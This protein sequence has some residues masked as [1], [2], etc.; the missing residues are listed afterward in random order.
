[1][2]MTATTV[3]QRIGIGLIAEAEQI[4]GLSDWGGDEFYEPFRLLV[5]SLVADAQLSPAGVESSREWLLMRLTQR[6]KL[7]ED[8]KRHPAI[9]EQRIEHPIFVAGMPRAGTTFMHGLLASDPVAISP[10]LWQLLSVSPPPNLPGI[11]NSP[12][13]EKVTGFMSRQ[14]WSHPEFSKAHDSDLMTPEECCYLFELAFV[15]NDWTGWWHVPG[16]LPALGGDFGPSYAM[17]HK[18]LQAMQLGTADKRWVLKAPEHS[19]HLPALLAQYP[20]AIIVQHHRDPAKVMASMLKLMQTMHEH[21]SDANHMGRETARHFMT[22]YAG[23]MDHIIA[24]RARP[25]IDAQIIDVH[26]KALERDPMG[27]V[28]QIY[29]KAGLPLTNEARAAIGQ[30]ITERS[31]G[32][33]GTFVYEL[34]DYGISVRDV[35]D[36]FAD[37]L[38]TYNIELEA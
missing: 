16:Y 27:T 28:E 4:S 15:S 34:A 25:E 35:H 9:G 19:M 12:E 24:Q 20:D 22:L 29:E 10:L 7:F 21:Y 38:D 37:Y 2:S 5:E 14:Y 8:R 33:H 32:R 26:Y 6:L 13:L 17:H 23:A 3:G 11:D 18:V 1:M 36:A 31:K 30:R